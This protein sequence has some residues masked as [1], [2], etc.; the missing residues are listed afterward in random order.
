MLQRGELITHVT[1]PKP[2]GGRH[3]YLVR[4][5]ASYAFAL[6]SVAAVVQRRRLGAVRL[7]WSCAEAVARRELLRDARRCSPSDAENAFKIALAERTLSRAGG[8]RALMPLE[9][10][11]P[12]A[13]TC[14]T[15]P[16]SSASRRR[17]STVHARP[18]APPPSAPRRGPKPGLRLHRRCGH[19]QGASFRWM[20]PAHVPRPAYWRSSP[21]RKP[22][23]SANRT[24]TMRRCSADPKWPTPPGHRVRGGRDL[25]AGPRRRGI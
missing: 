9:F 21:H 17:A 18:P 10:N 5:R 8:R 15:R 11:A 13:T 20:P 23:R 2:L 14:S 12:P 4:D 24:G 22:S 1:L 16:R 25:R 19:R 6:V 7:R 3:V